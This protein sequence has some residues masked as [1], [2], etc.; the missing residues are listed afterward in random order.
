V[1]SIPIRSVNRSER[2]WGPDAKEFKPERWI[3]G[4]MQ[5]DM[6]KIQGYRH[7]LSFGDGPRMCLGKPFALAAFKVCNF[8]IG[9]ELE[10]KW[11][12]IRP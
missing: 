10:K 9:G 12:L 4:D 1:V 11:I 6:T 8:V 7:L 3:G 5:G 2:F